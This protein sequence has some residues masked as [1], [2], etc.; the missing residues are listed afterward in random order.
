MEK[1]DAR[2]V[3][4][5]LLLGLGWLGA[6]DSHAQ[7]PD[8][9]SGGW[10]RQ[11]IATAD[12]LHSGFFLNDATG[13]LVTHS[14]GLV[15]HTTDGGRSWSTQ[16]RLEAG[17]L[18]SIFFADQ[19][20]GWICGDKG[21]IYR[22]EDGGKNWRQ[23]GD[24]RPELVFSAVHF[25]N[26][27]QGLLVGMNTQSRQSVLFESSDGGKSWRDN[28]A[29]VSGTGLSG[30]ITF[31]NRQIGLIAAFNSLL[32]TTDGGKSWQAIGLG[33]GVVIRDITFL[34]GLTGF[35]V[36]HRGMLFTTED[37]GQNWKRADN[38]SDGLLRSLVFL[39]KSSGYL[40]GDKDSNGNSLWQTGDGGRS[41]QKAPGDFPDIHQII[42]TKNRLYLIGDSGTVLAR[43][44]EFIGSR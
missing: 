21:R 26:R 42:R 31:I 6:E 14:T 43:G 33:Q 9:Q 41:W 10:E 7:S 17:Y 13:W 1:R 19:K 8:G 36:G 38:I 15:L 40:A 23:I 27:K 3:M 30:A 5:M 2:W 35:A 39:D 28:S 37:R 18:E 32:R 12:D 34:D 16:T 11:A 25:F 44:L 4:I 20:N 22:T 24:S 29:K